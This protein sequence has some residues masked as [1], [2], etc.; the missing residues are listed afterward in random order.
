MD[1]KLRTD[2]TR[3]RG[4]WMKFGVL[5]AILL[6][7]VLLV[8]LARPFI[9]NR[10]VPAIMGNGLEQ[11]AAAGTVEEAY[12]VMMP[13]ITDSPS[14]GGSE[15]AEQMELEPGPAVDAYPVPEMELRE[16]AVAVEET[17]EAAEMVETAVDAIV[18]T[19][20]PGENLTL[21]A[22]K[23]GVTVQ[24]ILDANDIPN[25]NRIV[26]GTVLRIPQP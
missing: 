17:E 18:Y 13:M 16:E 3:Q 24:D 11:P 20:Q 26:A 22:D 12:P 5:A 23:H 4:E 1:E 6:G 15:A 8:A 9:F 14:V 21:I 2:S 19:V 7:V 10:V 25:P